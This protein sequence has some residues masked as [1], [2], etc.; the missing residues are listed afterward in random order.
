MLYS[1]QSSLFINV[2]QSSTSTVYEL[3]S[4]SARRLSWHYF[5]VIGRLSFFLFFYIFNVYVQPYSYDRPSISTLLSLTHFTDTSSSAPLANLR[6]TII[7]SINVVNLPCSWVRWSFFTKVRALFAIHIWMM[8]SENSVLNRN[9]CFRAMMIVQS[10]GRAKL[11]IGFIYCFVN[12]SVFK[13]CFYF[14]DIPKVG[15]LG[16]WKMEKFL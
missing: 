9:L 8:L 12:K 4:T 6:F 1:C 3:F 5:L 15:V 14:S 10:D 7:K 16:I 2:V 13:I 11:K